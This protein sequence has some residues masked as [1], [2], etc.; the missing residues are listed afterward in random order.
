MEST[1]VQKESSTDANLVVSD[2]IRGYIDEAEDKIM[3]YAEGVEGAVERLID[4]AQLKAA[5]AKMEAKDMA[6]NFLERLE[7]M[8]MNVEMLLSTASTET[9]EGLRKLAQT[10]DELR[11]RVTH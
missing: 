2:T 1:Q 11:A 4:T 6:G 3:S 9:A 8:K 7:K 5:L 10:C